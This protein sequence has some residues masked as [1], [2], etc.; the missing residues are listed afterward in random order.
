MDIQATLANLAG[1]IAV[2]VPTSFL[3]VK[4]ALLRFYSEKLFERRLDA[5]MRIFDSLHVMARI[6]E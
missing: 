6:D 5:Y 1:G 2:S 4:L 3:T